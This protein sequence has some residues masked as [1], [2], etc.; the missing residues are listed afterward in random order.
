MKLLQRE[1][2]NI[3]KSNGANATIIIGH[4]YIIF[5][6]LALQHQLNAEPEPKKFTPVHIYFDPPICVN[7]SGIFSNRAVVKLS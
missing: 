2:L 1:Q 5:L 6:A 7:I 4:Q 3:Y